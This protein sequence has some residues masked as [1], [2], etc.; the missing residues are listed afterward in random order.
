MTIALSHA[1][2]TIY[3]SPSQSREL[4]VA[5]VDG[6][7]MLVRDEGASHSGWRT[8][9]RSLPGC[10]ISSIIMPE[11]GLILAG[12]FGGGVMASRDGESWEARDGGIEHRD[13]YSLA[14]S[15]IG[16]K[17]RLF[18][19][20]EPAHF[21]VSDDRGNNWHEMP[22]LRSVPSVSKWTF[23]APPHVG[24]VKWI[25]PDPSDPATVYACVE[26][27]GMFRSADGGRT[28]SEL[29]GFDDDVHRMLV[30]PRDSRRL[31]VMTGIGLYLSE[32]RGATWARLTDQ[33]SEIGAYPD[34]LVWRPNQP[35]VMLAGGAAG[36]PGVW[37]KTRFAGARISR[38]RNGGKSWEILGGGLPKAEE[39]QASIEAMSL[40]D[41]GESFSVFAATTAGEIWAS[42]DGAQRWSR[43]ASGLAPISKGEHY[44]LL[45]RAA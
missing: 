33:S 14:S 13:V 39:W 38:S 45:V 22:A 15:W 7:V 10:H 30:D 32:N 37:M 4:M 28:W 27:G 29:A 41:W 35:D 43:I 6:I 44:Q 42:E 18:A 23:P 17:L 26:Q 36:N 24:H 12:V 19:G 8:L 2:T 31:Y 21:Y 34:V 1:G 40:E 25:M 3:T 20:T 5:T 16:G 9:R 11:P